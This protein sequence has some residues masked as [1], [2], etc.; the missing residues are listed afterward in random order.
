MLDS[1]LF[2]FSYAGVQHDFRIRRCMCQLTV[3]RRVEQECFTLPGL[4]HLRPF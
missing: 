1:S 4:L 3:T 2:T